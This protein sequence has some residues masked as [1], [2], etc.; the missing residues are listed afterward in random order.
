MQPPSSRSVAFRGSRRS[1]RL[2]PTCRD[3]WLGWLR[4]RPEGPRPHRGY[5]P[6][7]PAVPCLPWAAWPGARPAPRPPPRRSAV[8]RVKDTTTPGKRMGTPPARP[9]RRDR[10]GTPPPTPPFPGPPGYGGAAWPASSSRRPPPRAAGTWAPPAP[11]PPSRPSPPRRKEP[12]P[13]GRSP[14]PVGSR[15]RKRP[16]R[17]R[18]GRPDR[19]CGGRHIMGRGGGTFER[20]LGTGRGLLLGAGDGAGAR[21]AGPGDAPLGR[22]EVRSARPREPGRARGRQEPERRV[23]GYQAPRGARRGRSGAFRGK[24]GFFSSSARVR[25]IA[26][27]RGNFPANTPAVVERNQDKQKCLK[28][29]DGFIPCR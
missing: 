12:R 10:P 1:V 4:P 28:Q 8:L 24:S 29:P 23:R 26:G 2:V 5:R 18:W 14:A 7:V 3:R 20:L 16:R 21:L 9:P 27:A 13:A 22:A 25:G 15:K 17:G 6:A 11:R 19:W